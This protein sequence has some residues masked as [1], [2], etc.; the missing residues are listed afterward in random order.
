MQKSLAPTNSRHFDLLIIG[1]GIS[2]IAAAYYLQTRCRGRSFAILEARDA[3]GGTWDLFRYPGIRSDSDLYTFG[4]S[5]A[6]WREEKAIAE[7]SLILRY[8]RETASRFGITSKIRFRERVT[9]AAWDSERA[10][11]TL[12][13]VREGETVRYSCGFLYGCTGYYDYSQGYM[14]G[15]P[16]MESFGGQIVHPQQWPE[17][18]DY[19]GRRVLVIGSGA[20]AVT[21]VPAL[22]EHASHVT[23]LQ[24]S[25]TYI[26]AMPARDRIAN[27]LRR[28]LPERTAFSLA[29]WKNILLTIFFYNLARIR[30]E[31]TK[32][33]I[34]RL[35]KGQLPEHF[36]AEKHLAPR[37]NPWDQRLCLVPDADLFETL[38]SG[39]ASI[40]TDEIE[41]FTPKGVRTRSGAELDAD[42]IVTA[43]GLK[44]KLLGGI[45]VTI[46]GARPDLTKAYIYRGMMLSD[47][48]N[49]AFAVG[50]TNA[51]WTLK[52]ELSARYLC[53]LLNYMGRK[54]FSAATPRA[55]GDPG[56][57][58]ALGLT[59]GY[60]LRGLSSLPRQ[61]KRPP[62]KLYQNYI[63]DLV[64]LR[65]TPVADGTME[66]TKTGIEAVPDSARPKN[67]AAATSHRSS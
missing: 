59:S 32:R 56:N 1:A 14:P 6:P 2:G 47:I 31:G 39:R 64:T 16:G 24:R 35:A 30:P 46:D 43:T 25:P 29:R 38:S 66:F 60:V 52:A 53:R 62:W 65:C 11:W 26:V 18:L 36:E 45:G 40:V 49:L 7:G 54:G 67:V 23:M 34:L 44:L 10:A 17:G 37:Y 51:S 20:T 28:R 58:P 42:I 57:E 33:Q 12:D 50:Y 22:A 48:P 55:H 13:A 61:G 41:T 8:L 15:W 9:N 27:W 21:L 5:F 4:F 19:A 63:F 3:I